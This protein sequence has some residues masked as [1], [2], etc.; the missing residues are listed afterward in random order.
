[1]LNF[2]DFENAINNIVLLIKSLGKPST[3]NNYDLKLSSIEKLNINSSSQS[4][5]QKKET[6]NLEKFK[7]YV[8]FIRPLPRMMSQEEFDNQLEAENNNSKILEKNQLNPNG[9]IEEEKGSALLLTKHSSENKSA[10]GLSIKDVLKRFYS[11]GEKF[12]EYYLNEGDNFE[13]FSIYCEYSHFYHQ[14]STS[15]KLELLRKHHNKRM[16]EDEIDQICVSKPR[17]SYKTFILYKLR[18]PLY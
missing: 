2:S 7:R 16:E 6:E 9:R 13:V 8:S 3:Q 11:K 1:M 14:I 4:Q 5:N 10:S 15:V 18:L 17:L 12:V